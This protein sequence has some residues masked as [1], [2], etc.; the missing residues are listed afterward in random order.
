MND[1]SRQ[2]LSTNKSISNQIAKFCRL[3]SRF[4]KIL[5]IKTLFKQ[6][7]GVKYTLF[8]F[9][10]SFDSG[11]NRSY[12]DEFSPL[13]RTFPD[14]PEIFLSIFPGFP[15]ILGFFHHSNQRLQLLWGETLE[16]L[17]D[18]CVI[19]QL[20]ELWIKLHL[21]RERKSINI[22]VSDIAI[23]WVTHTLGYIVMRDT[24]VSKVCC[25]GV[26]AP[27]TAWLNFPAHTLDKTTDMRD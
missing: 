23:H 11:L 7:Q 16:F 15:K 19:I 24:G 9:P 6:K 2:I 14:S 22:S 10:K 18:V 5:S 3:T 1:T 12:F 25:K 17:H 8:K 26:S 21:L 13:S 27:G 20:Q 4:C